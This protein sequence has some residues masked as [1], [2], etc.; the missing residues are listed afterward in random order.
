MKSPDTTPFRVLH[1]LDHS[2]PLHS[3][4]TFR[5][6][7]LLRAQAQRGWDVSAVT[8]PKHHEDWKG[9]WEPRETVG[10][11]THYRTGPVARSGVPFRY[12]LRI[13][14]ALT[15][16]LKEICAETRPGILHAHSPVLNAFPALRAGRELGIP[17]V[18]EIRAFWE[19]AAVD[20]GTYREGS[21]K[22]RLVRHLE[23]TACRRAG[24]VVVLCDGLR[25]DL[26]ARGIPAEKISVVRNGINT[27]DFK[28]TP[29]DAE[30]AAQQGLGGKRVI[31][32]LGSFYRYEGLDLL[33]TAFQKVASSLPDA[34]LLLAGGGEMEAA[35]KEQ[36]LR[37]GLR[38]KVCIPGRVL[39][40][41]IPGLYALADVLAFPRYSMR[42]TDLVTPLKPLEAMAMGRP[43]VASD[44]GGHRELIR[45]GETGLLFPAGNSSALAVALERVLT[46]AP[47]RQTLAAQGRAWVRKE[48]PWEKTTAVYDHVYRRA[49]KKD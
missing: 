45:D 28:D 16:R 49:R 20:H 41:R 26:I 44:V 24:Q 7:N 19:D 17:V 10:G 2:L 38:D 6:L 31:A 21:W 47:L 1:V 48:H 46:D 22:Y 18:Y 32:F 40:E 5:S 4:Y 12:E 34:V 42:L 11:L 15:R 29:P 8:S 30:F 43:V 25:R 36:A 35:L 27:T 39:H 14:G 23:T 37:L 33:V 3:G 13:L 9:P